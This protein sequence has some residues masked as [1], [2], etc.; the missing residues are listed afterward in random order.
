M[1]VWRR[2]AALLCATAL[3]AG[4]TVACSAAEQVSTAWKVKHA[5]DKLGARQSVSMTARLDA[6]PEQIHRYLQEGRGTGRGPRARENAQL[7]ADLELAVSVSADKPLRELTDSDRADSAAA[8]NFG[9]LDVFGLKSVDKKLYLRTNPAALAQELG[10]RGSLLGRVA[11]LDRLT[12]TLPPSLATAKSALSGDWVRVNPNEFGEFSEAL[13]GRAGAGTDRAA[14]STAVLRSA[15]LQQ[16]LVTAVEDA[17]GRHATFRAAGHHDGAEHVTL[18]LPAREVGRQL[19]AALQ[20]VRA[21]LGDLDL[22]VLERAPDRTVEMDLA[23]RHET[24]STLTVDV[25]QFDDGRTGRLPLQLTFAAGEAVS[26]AAPTGAGKLS[27]DD[28]LAALAYVSVR[29]PEL[30][31]RL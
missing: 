9:G 31:N 29:D 11:D 27:P 26:V 5:V 21:Q 6:T 15:T 22:S 20:P 8:V 12:A 1:G 25:G 24:L 30:S 2:S 4:G 18:R 10:E 23:I 7:L 28:L 16:R 19:A 13:G 17:L 14:D 3:L